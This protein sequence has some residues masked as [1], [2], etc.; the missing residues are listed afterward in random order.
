MRKLA[1]LAAG[2]FVSTAALAQDQNGTSGEGGSQQRNEAQRPT[3]AESN[4]DSERLICRMVARTESRLSRRRE[5]RTRAEW[6]N[7]SHLDD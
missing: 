6:N 7:L 1:F 3:N 4:A 5:C 2:L